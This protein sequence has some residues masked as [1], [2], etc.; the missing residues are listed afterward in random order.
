MEKLEKENIASL[1]WKD[2]TTPANKWRGIRITV[3]NRSMH[4]STFRIESCS[5]RF[6]TLKYENEILLWAR[7][8][9]THY[10][11]ALIKNNEPLYTMPIVSHIRS[12]EIEKR[13]DLVGVEKF[14][15]WSKF[16]IQSL[17]RKDNHFFT[18]GKWLIAPFSG[19]AYDQFYWKYH[20]AKEMDKSEI[21]K[22]I[23]D[24]LDQDTFQYLSWFDTPHQAVGYIGLK[25]VDDNDGRLKWWRKKAREGTLPPILL[26]YI[27]GLDGYVV[28]DGHY[29]L[30][31]AQLENT[32]PDVLVLSTYKVERYQIDPTIQQK[33]LKSLEQRQRNN[34]KT[35]A[36]NIDQLNNILINAYTKEEIY[37]YKRSKSIQVPIKSCLTNM[38]TYLDTIGHIEVCTKDL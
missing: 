15:S 8:H 28:I 3:N 1:Y 36:I 22:C 18:E 10:G 9:Y 31:A 35:S 30:R 19:N 5:K 17:N 12:S 20:A 38:M 4:P 24:A 7:Q 33:V 11:V 27:S 37:V 6:F 2:I 14:K 26:Y 21:D 32:L 25:H 29:R 13:K 34:R 16:F 23:F